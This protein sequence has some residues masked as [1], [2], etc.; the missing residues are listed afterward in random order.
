[1]NK[2]FFYC[3]LFLSFNTYGSRNN[4]KCRKA[5]F[6]KQSVAFFLLSFSSSNIVKPF[7]YRSYSLV[8]S[9]KIKN[10][11][12][13]Y[14]YNDIFDGYNEENTGNE[15][16][17]KL[18][19]DSFYFLKDV[20]NTVNFKALRNNEILMFRAIMLVQNEFTLSLLIKSYSHS[21]KDLTL[22]IRLQTLQALLKNSG[23]SYFFCQFFHDEIHYLKST[24]LAYFD[25][26]NDENVDNTIISLPHDFR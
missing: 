8:P 12:N 25:I 5:E 19:Q 17:N 23:N 24:L 16:M 7:H 18:L 13:L 4:R 2:L 15:V 10:R 11:F 21:E 3:F 20:E 6:R 1:M 22:A 26:E 9:Y 14:S